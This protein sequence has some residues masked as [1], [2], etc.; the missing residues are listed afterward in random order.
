MKK[1]IS[2][3]TELKI[4][5]TA[6]LH[7][8]NNTFVYGTRAKCWVYADADARIFILVY[9]YHCHNKFWLVSLIWSLVLYLNLSG[10]F[11]VITI[12]HVI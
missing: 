11:R 9:S 5:R 12:R 1:R 8:T 4:S 10:F 6:A 2:D 7:P 3:I